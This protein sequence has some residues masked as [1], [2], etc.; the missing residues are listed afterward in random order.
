MFVPDVLF[1]FGFIGGGAS[2]AYAGVMYISG[3]PV[4]Q[5]G[6]S[7]S[8]SMIGRH[9]RVFSKAFLTGWDNFYFA[10]IYTGASLGIFSSKTLARV[11]LNLLASFDFAHSSVEGDPF[12]EQ[13]PFLTKFSPGVGASIE[14]MDRY[15][16]IA[17]LLFHQFEKIKFDSFAVYR[18]NSWNAGLGLDTYGSH[19]NP[20]SFFDYSYR[21]LYGAVF[22][23]LDWLY[24]AGRLSY[25]EPLFVS[26]GMKF[27]YTFG[28]MLTF[29][30]GASFK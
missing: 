12:V 19:L 20:I 18:G 24:F 22:V 5:A 8:F 27:I 3:N 14:V 26:L 25:P 21:M 9:H 1:D 15:A 16:L 6:A 7:Y 10:S 13:Y 23:S 2:E 11:A 29:E 17:T 30:F 4:Y 28:Y